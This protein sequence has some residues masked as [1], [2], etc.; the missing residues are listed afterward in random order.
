M[1]GFIHAAA[2]GGPP[3]TPP[4]AALPPPAL[5][6]GAPAGLPDAEPA[7]VT[8]EQVRQA[9]A[10]GVR[11]IKARQQPDGS[12]AEHFYA[13]GETALC[14]LA[15]LQAGE[16]ADSPLIQKALPHILAAENQYTYVVGLKIM[17]L[18]AIDARQ[19]AAEIQSAAKWLGDAQTSAGLWN[20]TLTPGRWDHSNTQFALLGLHAAAEAGARI[21]AV[22]WQKAQGG[23]LR[24]QN[25]DGGWTYQ[26]SGG[27]SYG[28]MTAAAVAGLY[29]CGST[30]SVGR[31]RGFLD[32]AAPGCGRYKTNAPLLSGLSWLGRNFSAEQNPGKGRSYVFYWL[33]AVERCGIFSGQRY[34]GRHD[35]YREGAAY[36]VREQNA[37]GSWGSEP[38]NTALAVLFLAKGHKPLLIQKLQWAADTRWNPDRY[39]VANLVDFI[40]DRLGEPVAWQVTPFDAPLEDW[41]SA[42]LLYVQGH[43]FPEWD[44]AARRKLRDFVDRGGTLFF[45]ACCGREAF[46]EGFARFAAETFPEHALRA[47]DGGHGVYHALFDLE[48][49]GLQGIDLGCRTSVIYSPD[50]LSC[51]WEQ[52][53][54]PILSERALK[55]GANLAAYAAGR[56]PLRDRLD[57]V[58]LPADEPPASEADAGHA[59][60]LGQVVYDGDWR[61]DPHALVHF[62][63]FLRD[64]VG[65]DVVTAFRPVRLAEAELAATPIVYLSGHYAFALSAAETA[66]LAAHLQRGGFL[67]AESCCGRADFDAAFRALVLAAFPQARFERLPA[68]HPIFRGEPGFPLASVRYR[69]AAPGAES[70]VAPPELWGLTLGGR[71][72]AVYSPHGIGCGLD[73]HACPN[74]RGLE[75][76]DARKLAANVVLWAMTR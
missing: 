35:W 76:D 54:I 29:V 10:A 37:D 26:A 63:E 32:G 57:V 2:I 17:V 61:P 11:L 62:A 6:V 34:F 15:L 16:P 45:E 31:E 7:A 20:Y 19:Y 38:A 14:V 51:L 44:A 64:N 48:P 75:R 58:V 52:A 3:P 8:G 4:P 33:Y 24:S 69:P 60:R 53:A 28:S 41:L 71:L 56:Q 40:G 1:C 49:A 22:V 70:A 67:L 72:S 9:L 21:P 18:A 55:L 12:W 30:L 47:L 23:L 74:C 46:R 42:P 13:G 5:P 36:L 73:G 43:E 50:D 39:D 27:V 68:D 25:R 59:L 65:L 66:A